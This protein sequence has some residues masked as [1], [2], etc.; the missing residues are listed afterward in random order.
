VRYLLYILALI[1]VLSFADGS[2]VKPAVNK[3]ISSEN[4]R[5]AFGQISDFARDQYMLDTKTGKL[6]SIATTTYK[7]DGADKEIKILM[8]V[9]YTDTNLNNFSLSPTD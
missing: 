7:V 5:F 8:P 9:F 6:W 4:G 2:K 1:P 3:Q